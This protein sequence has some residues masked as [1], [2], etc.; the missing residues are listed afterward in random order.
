MARAGPGH[1]LTGRDSTGDPNTGE[2]G[3]SPERGEEFVGAPGLL[4]GTEPPKL[5]C[6]SSAIP[7]TWGCGENWMRS[8]RERCWDRVLYQVTGQCFSLNV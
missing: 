3:S 1:L 4:S 8:C 2:F 7:A 5:P 6:V